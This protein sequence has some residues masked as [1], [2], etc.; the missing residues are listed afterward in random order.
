MVCT[1]GVC[2]SD[3]FFRVS[4]MFDQPHDGPNRTIRVESND[5]AIRTA[6]GHLPPCHGAA[7]GRSW[8]VSDQP[9]I[10]IVG[11]F[12]LYEKEFSLS[13]LLE[14]RSGSFAADVSLFVVRGRW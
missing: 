4:L 2:V 1:R 7:S 14:W 8:H 12:A 6:F 9:G 10:L 13:V 5:I 3:A 11:F